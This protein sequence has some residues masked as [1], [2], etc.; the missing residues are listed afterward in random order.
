MTP[1]VIVCS[2]LALLVWPSGEAARR[3]RRVAGDAP[4]AARLRLPGWAA[5]VAVP[6]LALTVGPAAAVAAGIVAAVWIRRV[7]ARSAQRVAVA[8]EAELRRALAVMVAEMSVGSPM[9]GACRA[10]A[11]ELGGA[12]GSRVAGELARIAAHVELGGELDGLPPGIP[13]SGR[14]FQAWSTSVRH[15]LPMAALLE[16]VRRDL[17]QRRD[18][19]A[20]TEA[21]LAGPRAT[22]MVLAGLPLLGI[23]LGQ[24]MGAHPIGVLLNSAP[25]GILLVVGVALAAAG[26]LWA[27]AIVAKV[28]R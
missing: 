7:R 16:A 15:G 11:D 26:V 20:R 21:S 3:M 10:A 27:D 23:G 9:V 25:G 12:G 18:F 13:G 4:E 22:A 8:D 17:A 24:L 14:I 6:A 28:L 5:V 19:T 1:A 2:A